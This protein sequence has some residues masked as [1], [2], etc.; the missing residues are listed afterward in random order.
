MFRLSVIYFFIA[1][2]FIYAWRD[3]FKVLCIL[4]LMMA[5]IKDEDMP[6]NMFGIQGFNL[7]N[8]LFLGIFFAWIVNRIR[9]GLCWDMPR[10][11]GILLL[12]YLAVILVGV[13]RAALDSSNLG[14][15]AIKD[16]LSEEL[17]NT[18]KWVLPGLL[19]FD[20]CRSRK[21]VSL[22]MWS[23]LGCY[24]LISLQVIYRVPW[25]CALG[26]RDD[27]VINALS[28]ACREIGYT[29]VDMSTFLAGAFWA[30][31]AT[32]PMIPRKKYKALVLAAAGIVVFGQALTGGR[33]GYV[34]WGATGL[35]L[36][37]LKWRKYLLLTPF[38]V[39]FLPI[40][41]P[42]AVE[43][44][45][46]G[47]NQTDVAGQSTTDENAITSDRMLFWPYII[48]TIGESPVIGF[49]RRAMNRTGLVELIETE[50]PGI[51]A[52]QPHNMYLET[53]LDNGI[54]GSIPILIFWAI[55]VI[56]AGRLFI[57][58]NRLCS[59]VGG[60]TLALMLAQLFAGIGSQHFYPEESTLGVWA[61]MFLML[62]VHIEQV[63]G[64]TSV[65]I[66]VNYQIPEQIAVYT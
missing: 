27:N 43:R 19:L 11:I 26:G 65:A 66:D 55:L 32:L 23:L 30:I 1:F 47:F 25:S 9:Q 63:R 56:Y 64:K 7:W 18:I 34:A 21:R 10:H 36:G 35:T 6:T 31:I 40:V 61:A 57:G 38:L 20:G 8:I 17:I 45:F 37:I 4:I 49:G 22:A 12:I 15:Y 58:S 59:A 24:F 13:L 16:L 28:K 33:A 53:L 48:D 39:I 46:T 52:G 29:P 5:V 60:M 14:G 54:L 50:H 44:M 62:R 3:W 41:F 42:G 51:G 2:L